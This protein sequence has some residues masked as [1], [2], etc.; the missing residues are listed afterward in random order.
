MIVTR[1]SAPEIIVGKVDFHQ[2]FGIDLG[3]ERA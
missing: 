1:Q 3:E 2:C